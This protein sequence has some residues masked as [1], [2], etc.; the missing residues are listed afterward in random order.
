MANWQCHNQMVF[1]DISHFSDLNGL[2]EVSDELMV[3]C[4]TMFHRSLS[5]PL[6]V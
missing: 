6:A 5:L 1:T 3:C 2:V 4:F